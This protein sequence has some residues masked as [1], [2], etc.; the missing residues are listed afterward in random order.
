MT[1]TAAGAN[2]VQG[3]VLLSTAYINAL[4]SGYGMNAQYLCQ[5]AVGA[6]TAM[7]NVGY[8]PVPNQPGLYYPYGG[9]LVLQLTNGMTLTIQM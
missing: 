1:L 4:I 5:A 3:T 8:A 2:L 7:I 9:F 6:S